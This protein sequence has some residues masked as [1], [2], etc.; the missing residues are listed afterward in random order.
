VAQLRDKT[1]EFEKAKVRVVLVGMGP[2]KESRVFLEHFK[3]PF[4]MI[5]DPERKLYDIYGLKK[6][7]VLGFLSPSLALKSLSAVAQGNMAGIPEGDVKQLAGIF[8]I[9]N[10]GHIRFRH[11][12]GDP[13]D[14][15]SAE[16]V[17]EALDSVL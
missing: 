2:P 15:P 9:D 1:A 7:G 10:S 11:L 12:S 14:F 13:A 5:C 8:I 3:V 6:M 16:D 17:L 4:P